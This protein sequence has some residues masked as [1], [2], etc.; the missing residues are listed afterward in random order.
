[1]LSIVQEG[2][3]G[4]LSGSPATILKEVAEQCGGSFFEKAAFDDEGMIEAGVGGGIVEGTCVSGFGIRGRVDQTRETA[5]MGGAGAHGAWFQGGVEGAVCQ[6]PAARGGGCTTDGEELSVGGGIPCSLTLVCGDGQNLLSPGDDSSDRDLALFGGLLSGEQGAAHH[7]DVGLRRIV[8]QWRRHEADDSSLWPSLMLLWMELGW[9]HTP[10]FAR[11]S[12]IRVRIS[13]RTFRNARRRSSWLPAAFEGSGK[14]LC[15]R[16]L[17][18]RKTLQTDLFHSVVWTV[19]LMF[20]GCRTVLCTTV[21]ACPLAGREAPEG[22]KACCCRLVEGTVGIVGG[23]FFAVEGIWGCAA[24]DGAVAFVKLEAEDVSR[25]SQGL[26]FAVSGYDGEGCG[27]FVDLAALYPD[28]AILEHVDATD[29]VCAGYG[30]KFGNEIYKRQHFPIERLWQAPFE[31]ELDVVRLVWGVL[32]RSG[33]R[34]DVFGGF[35]VGVFQGSC[36]DRAAPEVLVH[37]VR[38]FFRCGDGDPVLLGVGHLLGA[39]HVPVADWGDN[40]Q[41]R[42]DGGCRHIEADLIVTFSSRAVRD[43]RRPNLPRSLNEFL[44]YKRAPEGREERVFPAVQRVSHYC[45]GDVLLGE[46]RPRIPHEGVC[47][48]YLQRLRLYVL[49]R[50]SLAEIQIQRVGLRPLLL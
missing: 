25:E 45:R 46:L 40:R 47:G 29:T 1:M 6:S 44:R 9:D 22:Y 38:G 5:C 32:G 23:K 16:S 8:C 36:F 21:D 33:E 49:R 31:A 19:G 14:N 7:G 39:A 18:P 4:S 27:G 10:G 15:R 13:S 41:V 11:S 12:W 43:V 20:R 34:E 50:L 3:F 37:A 35:V 26:E 28:Q 2:G 24:C 30:S 17:A 42:G 48:A